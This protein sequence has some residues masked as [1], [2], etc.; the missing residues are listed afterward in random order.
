MTSPVC[1]YFLQGR[2]KFGARC[3]LA[4]VSPSG[5]SGPRVPP[6]VVL[7]GSDRFKTKLC[8]NFCATG[9]CFYGDQCIFAHGQHELRPMTRATTAVGHTDMH[10]PPHPHSSRVR[11]PVT[12]QVPM[13]P[14]RVSAPQFINS[15]GDAAFSGS[16]AAWADERKFAPF[17]FTS[18]ATP[19]V[20]A[21]GRGGGTS[22]TRLIR[23]YISP[24]VLEP[25]HSY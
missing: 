8:L 12:V 23:W 19:P 21:G 7:G 5:R 6:P 9:S 11:Q 3:A 15:Q 24:T 1:P 14:T 10:I 22:I 25:L 13:L 16:Y 20:A 18:V 2:C 17:D 4:H